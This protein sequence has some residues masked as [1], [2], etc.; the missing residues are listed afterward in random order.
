MF[1][2]DT[3]LEAARALTR[4]A[5]HMNSSTSTVLRVSSDLT[6]SMNSKKSAV[7]V[8]PP[9]MGLNSADDTCNKHPDTPPQYRRKHLIQ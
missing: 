5:I 6:S 7:D 3:S 8:L 2:S 9:M 4:M 1:A